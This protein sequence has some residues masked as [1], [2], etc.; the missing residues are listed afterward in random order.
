[1]Q[2]C[3]VEQQVP[4]RF[5]NDQILTTSELLQLRG[6]VKAANPNKK[7]FVAIPIRAALAVARA[8]KPAAVPQAPKPQAPKPATVP[9]PPAALTASGAAAVS[10]CSVQAALQILRA[11]T[12]EK[13]L[14]SAQI[15][16]KESGR[17]YADLY[18]LV[19]PMRKKHTSAGNSMLALLQNQ[20]AAYQRFVDAGSLM[21]TLPLA[22]PTPAPVPTQVATPVLQPLA[23]VFCWASVSDLFEARTV[24]EGA[25]KR[26]RMLLGKGIGWGVMRH[27]IKTKFRLDYRLFDKLMGHRV[28]RQ[29]VTF[30]SKA[31]AMLYI[32]TMCKRALQLC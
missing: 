16:F 24:P 17:S 25:N 5:D 27:T 19:F 32:Q 31:D 10:I 14:L 30:G 26:F 9:R 15:K 28:V 8:P 18:K 29:K 7:L 23:R 22:V 4:M 20:E 2:M 12:G 3:V 13:D 21:R 11:L 6:S 1:M